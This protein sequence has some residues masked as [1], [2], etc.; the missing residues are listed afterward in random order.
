M[1]QS[2]GQGRQPGFK[3][4]EQRLLQPGAKFKNEVEKEIQ[5]K[6]HEHIT[7]DRMH[8]N[9]IDPVR[10]FMARPLD[11]RGLLEK[12]HGK[13]MP[14]RGNNRVRGGAVF[15]YQLFFDRIKLLLKVCIDLAELLFK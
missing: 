12:T 2:S 15:I 9:I 4:L 3:N 10:P 1:V 6:Q 5:D 8:K 11:D 7:Q 14:F 13:I